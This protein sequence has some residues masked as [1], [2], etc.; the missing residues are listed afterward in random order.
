MK[1]LI[2]Y[3]AVILVNL[4][5]SKYSYSTDPTYALSVKNFN[6]IA[7]NILEF[8]IYMRNTSG[9][10]S[11]FEY[12]MGQYMFNF[13]T[14]F[15]N[16]GTLT[17]TVSTG[18]NISEL[19]NSSIPSC[20]SIFSNQL[21]VS[22]F[23]P[24]GSGN[25]T[26]ISETGNGTKIVRMR[27]QTT[28]CY[29]SGNLNLT[30]RTSIG[31]YTKVCAYVGTLAKKITGTYAVDS[32]I[33]TSSSNVSVTYNS[34]TNNFVNL[35]EAFKAI[36]LGGVYSGKALTIN[37]NNNTIEPA[38]AVLKGGIF[39]SCLIKPT[40]IVSVSAS[41][42]TEKVIVLDEADNVTIDGRINQTGSIALTIT[43][44]NQTAATC[45]VNLS[46]GAINNFIKFISCNI[47]NN[48][49]TTGANAIEI[50]TSNPGKGGN[51]DNK[52]EG[53]LITEARCGINVYGNSF[54]TNDRSII[55]KNI[56][57]N[58]TQT[59]I[60]GDINSRDNTIE[61]N[62]L[63]NTSTVNGNS[64]FNAILLRGVG[65]NNKIIKN[66]IYKL[67]FAN[68]PYNIVGIEVNSYPAS[69]GSSITTVDVSNNFISLG[70][71]S[72]VPYIDGILSQMFNNS[73]T[74]NNYYNSIYI[75]GQYLGYSN[76]DFTSGIRSFGG[77]AGCVYNQKNNISVN[78]RTAAYSV[79]NW[80]VASLTNFNLLTKNIDYNC[81]WSS[82]EVARWVNTSYTSLTE[83]QCA[84]SPNEQNTIFKDVNFVDAANG[85]LHLAGPSIGDYDL[86]GIAG[87]TILGDFDLTAGR[88]PT[89]PFMGADEST[90]FTF[91]GTIR[92]KAYIDGIPVPDAYTKHLT[93]EIWECNAAGQTVSATPLASTIPPATDFF[94]VT[95]TTIVNCPG[96]LTLPV[97]HKFYIKITYPGAFE[98][99]SKDGGE[100]T[101]GGYLNYDFTTSASQAYNGNTKTCG[102]KNYIYNGDTNNDGYIGSF[103]LDNMMTNSTCAAYGYPMGIPST[104]VI[105][106]FNG[107]G[108]TNCDDLDIVCKAI[109]F[110]ATVDV[111]PVGTNYINRP[112]SLTVA[113]DYDVSTGQSCTC[114]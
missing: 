59:G 79:I 104:G 106:D 51:N 11:N 42:C 83:Y 53:C 52:V 28:A 80:N 78:K 23:F 65:I 101:S 74:I 92:V 3:T 44:R 87:L 61:S 68:T 82:G 85:D 36:N 107:D 86:I 34:T 32:F 7:A 98:T 89:T 29:F 22:T 60:F 72:N 14:A 47:P 33:P 113:S 91:N 16:G 50:T 6:Y 77:L 17:Y 73:V 114:P 13:N 103:D 19:P 1:K 110:F 90:P 58:C 12:N 15:A 9:G 43:N 38:N 26:E 64:Y 95:G 21:R 37:I 62:Q 40:A 99:W 55:L 20:P 97:G 5:I 18:S 100:L 102:C 45:C 46:N 41:T 30:W 35:F 75:F 93:I 10:S 27:L 105:T 56:I 96:V 4:F 25:G 84:V 69:T 2:L 57:N 70:G 94:S 63:F 24:A 54:Y 31:Y 39:T 88:S 76:P 108:F 8:E 66:K 111:V 48:G 49:F 71:N 67:N 81:Y 112:P 109:Q